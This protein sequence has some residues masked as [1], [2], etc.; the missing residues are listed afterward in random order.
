MMQFIKFGLVGI[1]NLA[2][3]W[4]IYYG[5]LFFDTNYLVAN[6]LGWIFGVF[7]S[8]CWNNFYVFKHKKMNMQSLFKTYCTYL[9]SFIL[10]TL[11]LFILV[12]L[13][14][15]SEYIAPLIS[16]IIS[17]PFNFYLNKYWVYIS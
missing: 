12:E 5:L 10:G 17:V 16:I 14:N 15:V 8:Y 13:C 2:V 11:M 3:S 4:T 7:N 1:S 9:L 6:V